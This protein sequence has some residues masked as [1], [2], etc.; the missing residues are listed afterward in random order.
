VWAILS[1]LSTANDCLLDPKPASLKRACIKVGRRLRSGNRE[2]ELLQQRLDGSVPTGKVSGAKWPLIGK[3]MRVRGSYNRFAV[4]KVP[5]GTAKVIL[6]GSPK[7][8]LFRNASRPIV[9][10][11]AIA[12]RIALGSVMD[13]IDIFCG[14]RLRTTPSRYAYRGHPPIFSCSR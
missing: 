2:A 7:P 9:S 11:S 4:V 5:I 14:H 8:Y 6:T 3:L 13:D 10:Y 12:A 1:I